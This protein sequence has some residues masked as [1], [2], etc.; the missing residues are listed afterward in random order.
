MHDEDWTHYKYTGDLFRTWF[1]TYGAISFCPD[2]NQQKSGP[3][4]MT[5]PVHIKIDTG[6]G[7]YIA[8]DLNTQ[9]GGFTG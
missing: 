6:G 7:P 8:G 3:S 9:G 2:P 4:L 5:S 1:N